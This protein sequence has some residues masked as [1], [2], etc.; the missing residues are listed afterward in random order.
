MLYIFHVDTGT[1]ITFDIKLALQSVSQLMEAIE[2]DCGVVAAHQV[3]LMSGGECLEPTARVCSYSAGTDTNPIYLFSKAAIESSLPP[4]PSIDYGSDVDLQTQIDASLA[5]PATY[6]TVCARAHLAQQCCGLAREQTKICE[7]LVHDQHLQ[8]QGWA[9][10]VA[11]LEDITQMFQSRAEQF[12]Q[13]FVLYLAE[14]QQHMELLDNFSADLGTLAKIPILPALRAQAEGLLS[15]DDQPSHSSESA[16]EDSGEVLSLLRWISAKDNQSSLE[17]V[18]DQCSRGLEQFDERLMQALKAEVNTAIDNANKQEMKEIKGLGERLFALEQL[19][20]QTKRLVH[21]QGELAQGFLQNQNRAT[22]LGDAS[23]LPD[24]CTSHRRQLVVMLQ[25]HNQ[26]RDIRRRCTKAKEELSVNIYQR[27][28]WIMYVENKMVEVGNKL[29]IYHESLKRLRRH[30]E[31]LQQIHLAPQMYISAVV[32]VV[33]RRTFSQAFLVW[34]SNLACQLLTV[35]S[36]E[37][38]RRRE[39]QSK[40]DGHFLNTLF[41]GL[42][43]TPP[44]F[45]TQAPSVFDNELPKLTVDDME[46]LRSQ[47]P[48]LALAISTPNLNSITQFFLSKSF[49]EGSTDDN[50]EKDATSASTDIPAKEQDRARVPMLSDR[51]GFESETDTEE[52]EKIG[53]AGVDATKPSVF[54]GAKQK[55]QKQLEVGAS[56][57]VSPASST[58]TNVSPLNSKVADLTTRSSTSSEPGSFQFPSL[59]VASE[60]P[61]QLSPLT[62]CVENGAADSSVCLLRSGASGLSNYRDVLPLEEQHSLSPNPPSL[63]RSSVMC[64][65]QHQHQHPLSGSG[66]SSPS[67]G[68]GA[69]DFMGTEFYMDESLPSSLSEHPA[70]GQHQAIV[71]LLQENLGNTREEV[72]RLRSILKTMKAVVREE[73]TSVR[74]ELAILRDQSNDG[75]SLTEMTE[76]VRV[77]L[78]LYSQDC[79]SRLQEREQEL[80]IEHE[81]KMADIKKLMQNHEEEIC[82][83]K[84]NLLEKET[85]LAEHERLVAT[86][87]QKLEDEQMEKRN[88]QSRLHQQLEDYS[89]ILEQTRLDKEEAV[90][91]TNDE[92][93]LEITSLT[94]SLAQCQKRIQELEENLATAH[95]DQ[96]R[97]VKETT[98]KFQMEYKTELE[99]IRSRFKLMAAST[100]ERSPSD[101]S[102][103]KI[104]RTDVIEL[105]NHEAILAQAKEDMK[106]ES[107]MALRTAIEKERADCMAKLDN[108]L[109]LA[110]EVVEEKNREIDLYRVRTAALMEQGKHYKNTIDRLIEEFE[111]KSDIQQI[112]KEKMKNLETD[113]A[114]LESEESAERTVLEQNEN[115][116]Y[117]IEAAACKD[118]SYDRLTASQVGLQEVFKDV[119]TDKYDVEVSESKKVRL[120]AGD[121]DLTRLSRRLESLENDNKRLSCELKT[122]RAS[123]VVAEAKV[124]TLRTDK[125]RL[126]IELLNERTKSIFGVESMPTESRDKEMNASVAIVTDLTSSRDQATSPEPSRRPSSKSASTLIRLHPS[127]PAYINKKV[128]EKMDKMVQQGIASVTS[129]NAGDVVLVFWD[130]VHGN[131]AV[132][133]ESSTL[134][135]LHSDYVGALDIEMNPNSSRRCVLAEV[136]DKEYCH[137]RKENR[138]HVPRGTKFY[139][140]RAKPR[141]GR[142]LIDETGSMSKSQLP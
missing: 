45:A 130:A 113:K 46:S 116:V 69:T 89:R 15:L 112:L 78:S 139:R 110:K 123:K 95:S 70:D 5:M 98:D 19:M 96:E 97:I 141:D 90:K 38:A 40:F 73:L 35:H 94:N 32:E 140:V 76:R 37:L 91:K 64:D 125:I 52:F 27:L 135:F 114:R 117:P 67:V 122:I 10:V 28:K 58:S 42:E 48:D 77:A 127:F 132:Y 44:P 124:E 7:R 133:Q 71:S 129:C 18:A 105:V 12:Q 59:S 53:Q 4:T 74:N 56:R 21:E 101:S 1:T 13:A 34:A 8:Q 47:L 103:E 99:T 121:D 88:L 23:V 126:E 3:L 17:Q 14:R 51:G 83:L 63:T 120:E 24:L 142:A 107:A 75:K 66:G 118:P 100:M 39:F 26:L 108:E 134:Y 137:A 92:R 87:R 131:Y 49:T 109:R 84:R 82:T 86:M 119:D 6:Q 80:T 31:V 65:G 43:D 138:Y 30:L 36:E 61:A 68:V 85:E 136:I 60:R 79:D 22:N 115:I 33:R 54:D 55:R 62:E 29:I 57:S 9:A 16:S 106:V 41:P 20:V 128:A 111:F 2:R 50:K 104:E 81:F 72:E 93:F 11:N 102:L 25:N